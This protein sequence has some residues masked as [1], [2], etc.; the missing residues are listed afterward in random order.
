MNIKTAV[1]VAI[2]FG[3]GFIV[4]GKDKDKEKVI[5]Y[6]K[7][8]LKW[9]LYA[10]KEETNKSLVRYSNPINYSKY[11]KSLTKHNND[12][13]YIWHKCLEF[14]DRKDAVQV[15]ELIQSNLDRFKTISIGDICAMRSIACDYILDGYGWKKE[16]LRADAFMILEKA[17]GH[18]RIN[19]PM[20][21]F[22]AA[23]DVEVVGHEDAEEI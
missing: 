7:K 15:L 6:C 13:H 19:L 20:P 11:S 2:G 1:N 8:K 4:F 17:D 21:T 14:N 16:E 10:D 22:L 12:F 3:L 9:L 18:F 23:D 5:E